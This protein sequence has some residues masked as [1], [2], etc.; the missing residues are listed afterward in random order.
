MIRINTLVSL[1]VTLGLSMAALAADPANPEAAHEQP[2][3][4]SAEPGAAIWMLILFVLLLFVLGKF[5]WPPILAGLNAREEK[6]RGDITSAESANKAAQKTLAEYQRQLADAHA[7]A[8]KLVDQARADADAARQRIVAETEAEGARL[9]RR[10]AE[11]IEQAK[12]AA[13]QE[14]YAKAS[15]LSVAVAEKIL[16]RQI[17]EA[18]T[19]RLIDESLS[20]LDK[21]TKAS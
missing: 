12:N 4:L 18:D 19:Q 1:A 10:V 14:L 5:V 11:E 21:V 2:P 6:I 16:R 15:E 13:T 9:R 20:Q 8:R 17:T 7:E 3:L